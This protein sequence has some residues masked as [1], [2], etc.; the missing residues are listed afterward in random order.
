M[1]ST[2]AEIVAEIAKMKNNHTILNGFENTHH[3]VYQKENESS[4]MG[5]RKSLY[6]PRA[7]PRHANLRR[8]SA[9]RLEKSAIL[10][11]MSKDEIK[12][13]FLNRKQFFSEKG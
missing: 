5:K 10:L 12:V 3:K 11:L 7:L 13:D 8:H 9:L 4:T 1:A 2:T 6:L